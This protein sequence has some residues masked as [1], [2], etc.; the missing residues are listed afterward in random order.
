MSNNSNDIPLG[1]D[2]SFFMVNFT[3]NRMNEMYML[4]Q[5]TGTGN[6]MKLN[7]I[8][9]KESVD[10]YSDSTGSVGSNNYTLALIFEPGTVDINRTG[11]FLKI[12][13]DNGSSNWDVKVAELQEGAVNKPVVYLLLK[14]P[15]ASTI[16]DRRL[17]LL[18]SIF[19]VS[20]GISRA[21][22]MELRY[23][24]SAGNSY[25]CNLNN[26]NIIKKF[27]QSANPFKPIVSKRFLEISGGSVQDFTIDLAYVFKNP[28]SIDL[29]DLQ[30]VISFDVYEP[31]VESTDALTTHELFNDG[32]QIIASDFNNNH[33]EVDAFQGV[34]KI[35]GFDKPAL[36][37]FGRTSIQFKNLTPHSVV[38]ISNVKIAYFNVPGF[39]DG[40]MDIEMFRVNG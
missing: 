24:T 19:L 3:T 27:G 26:L 18:D 1:T 29:K 12:T 8:T 34:I 22:N 39:W 15:T 35:S 5:N 32:L 17:L 31:V 30:L 36:T 9:L 38:G 23:K 33:K 13:D 16:S 7:L 2:L 21:G 20:Q 6:K 11:S 4:G 40:E 14:D 37:Q 10:L 25:K 28:A